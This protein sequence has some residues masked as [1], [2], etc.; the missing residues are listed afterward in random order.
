MFSAATRITAAPVLDEADSLFGKRSEVKD[1]KDRYANMEN[2][3][4]L[5]Q[6]KLCRVMAILTINVKSAILRV[7]LPADTT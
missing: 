4:L 1:G 3:Y 2:S 7:D 6:V 5:A